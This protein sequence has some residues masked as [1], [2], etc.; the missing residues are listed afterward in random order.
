VL[1]GVLTAVVS[2]QVI[3][4]YVPFVPRALWTEEVARLC[5]AWLVFL[6]AAL[7]IRRHEHFVIDVIPSRVAERIRKPLQLIILV[8]IALGAVVIVM[9]GMQLAQTG[10]ARISTTS[11]FRLVWAYASMP[12]A[13]LCMLAFVFE[14]ALRTLRGEDVEEVGAALVKADTPD[15]VNEEVR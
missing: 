1:L 3:S 8:C 2:Y 15:I 5:L 13:G 14:L 10:V 11:G 4:R 12:V 7:A 6:G 9:G